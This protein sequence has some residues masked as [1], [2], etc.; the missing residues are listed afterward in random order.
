MA[1][2]RKL[3][4]GIRLIVTL[5]LI[6][7]GVLYLIF[8]LRY[9]P[10]V[11]QAAMLKVENDAAGVINDAIESVVEAG[12]VDYNSLITLEKDGNGTVTVLKTNMAAVNQL[13]YDI[14]NAVS[15]RILDLSSEKITLPAGSIF[16][17]ELFSGRGPDIPIR[18]AALRSSSAQLESQFSDAGINQT[19]HEIIVVV[20]IDVTIVTPAGNVSVPVSSNAVVAE[21]IIVG[22]VPE[23]FVNVGG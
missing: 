2:G 18:L 12:K 20:S 21:T 15:E 11:K 8:Q 19:R 4:N 17:P 3:R 5:V 1:V 23:T 13:K 10:I 7:G 22:S 9:A 14:L 16:F 6:I